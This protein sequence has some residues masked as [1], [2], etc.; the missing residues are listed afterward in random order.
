MEEILQ[1]LQIR[2][3]EKT[4]NVAELAKSAAEMTHTVLTSNRKSHKTL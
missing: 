4:L 2:Y 3:E 1:D